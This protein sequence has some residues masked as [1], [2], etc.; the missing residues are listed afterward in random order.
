MS[1]N[2]I[3]ELEKKVTTLVLPLASSSSDRFVPKWTKP[4]S[5]P[6][7]EEGGGWRMYQCSRERGRDS[8]LLYTQTSP[9]PELKELYTD[10]FAKETLPY[11]RG[12]GEA[13]SWKLCR[14]TSSRRYLRTWS[15]RVGA[16][17]KGAR[18]RR[19][20]RNLNEGGDQRSETSD[21]GLIP[22]HCT[23]SVAAPPP[24]LA[25]RPIAS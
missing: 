14:L 11:I 7:Y 5:L 19:R 16:Q 21:R 22:G 6:R 1:D 15:V 17:V 8:W 20:G 23:Q 13:V 25:S 24:H 9:E 10:V 3:K 12:T 2:E 18:R 4:L